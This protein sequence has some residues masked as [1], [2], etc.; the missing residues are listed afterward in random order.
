MPELGA[1]ARIDHFEIL[2]LLGQGGMG[3]V[4]LAVDH[5]LDR[6][7]AIKFLPDSLDDDLGRVRRFETEARAA[8]AL[9]HPNIVTIFDW[10]KSRWGPYLVMEWIEG[11]R[12]RELISEGIPLPRLLSL[13]R[14]AA[15]AISTAHRAGIV[16]R[17]LKPDNILVRDD[18]YV[19][20][21]DFGL[22]R[23]TNLD[24]DAT[25]TFGG[26]LMG[27]LKYLAPEQGAGTADERSDVF[28]LGLIFYQMATGRH[29]FEAGSALAT[30][31][32]LSTRPAIPPAEL[33]PGIPAELSAL[34]L[35]MLEK[36]PAARPNSSHVVESLREMLS[37]TVPG[38][39]SAPMPRQTPAK[40]IVGRD[41][42]NTVL[43]KAFESAESVRGSLV[44]VS[45]E[46]GM[47]KTALVESVIQTLAVDRRR[48][49][50]GRGRSSQ[51]LAGVEAYAP[52]LEALQEQLH[53]DASG[54]FA[55]EMKQFAPSWYSLVCSVS[56]LSGSVEVPRAHSQDRMKQELATMLQRVGRETPLAIV[57]EDFH[58][59][60][61]S[62]VDAVVHLANRFDDLR[63][64]MIVTY[65]KSEML[66]SN[67]PFVTAE[68]DLRARGLSQEVKLESLSRSE[69]ERYVSLEFPKNR[70]GPELLDKVYRRTGGHPL[71]VADLI[72]YLR[73][74][75]AITETDGMWETA[76]SFAELE[77]GLPE[78][79]RSM[80]ERK[81]GAVDEDDRRLL[82]SAAVQGDEFDSAVL[83]TVVRM[84]AAEVEER[85]EHLERVY[86]LISLVEER[87]MPDRT[88]TCRY[89]FAHS[90]YHEYCY[91]LLRPTRRAAIAGATA[92]RLEECYGSNA[93]EIAS[94]LAFL[95]EGA[96]EFERAGE[97]FLVAANN[98]TALFAHRESAAMARRGLEA[99]RSL[100][101][102]PKRDSQELR[103]QL[104]LGGSLCMTN[105]YASQDTI[106][107]FS[108]ALDLAKASG[109]GAPHPVI[110]GLWMAYAIM[111]DSRRSRELSD[112]LL[113]IASEAQ[114]PLLVATAHYASAITHE[115]AGDL[116]AAKSDVDQLIAIGAHDSN[117]RRVA[118]FVVDPL[119]SGRGIHLRTLALMGLG[120]MA[121]AR[122][123]S[124][125][126]RLD[127]EK[128]DPRSAC[129]I[130][131]SGC[132]YYAFLRRA[133]DV[134]ELAR[135]AAELSER[136]DIFVERQW[137]AFWH[138]WALTEM[139]APG[140]GPQAM[141]AFLNLITSA[142]FLL[143]HSL[144]IATFGEALAKAGE[145][146]EAGDWIARGLALV[147]RTG[148]HYYESELHRIRGEL[149]A[150]SND[151]D[152]A[153]SS[154]KRALEIATSQEARLL[155]IRAALS[156]ARF[157]EQEGSGAEAL[158]VLTDSVGRVT[159]GLKSPEFSEASQACRE[160][161][162]SI[163]RSGGLSISG[164]AHG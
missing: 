90:L 12:L 105:G 30:F 46:A 151:R 14:Q 89:R 83:S 73:E 159:A 52:L 71:F 55:R 51:R 33:N 47:G 24:G 149:A 150:R 20:V 135:R 34:V 145:L 130:L 60:D 74:S 35:N 19:K 41:A 134:R 27:T 26:M 110:W 160:L 1:G 121:S 88:L 86:A 6:K 5:R 31:H 49:L 16:H 40:A 23:L 102:S 142:G 21:V 115:I 68:L 158:R 17:D 58:W 80:V 153:R 139:G 132:C 43:L 117:P 4:Y 93:P 70:F 108:R 63:L 138:G 161:S 100:P 148:Q 113:R 96:R 92:R 13:A 119:I 78:S 32:A 125:R 82:S 154:L 2:S 18:G 162:Q 66:Q 42:E 50:L 109:E 144:Y 38:A 44:C 22:A 164:E 146:D 106:D 36:E 91:G 28:S 122:W 10:G 128:L 97:Y 126:R 131:I 3:Q 163:E 76:P 53:S 69:V 9:N 107:C 37:S 59:A 124:H 94:K 143:H 85:L 120:D 140:E 95:F 137:A 99:V 39:A 155:E 147:E 7:V 61:I 29:P 141:R 112:D 8:S 111:G 72:R 57:F 118:R 25:A 157:L 104:A 133:E 84:D 114:D 127:A 103:L 87:E 129:D 98:A 75:G 54:R 123:E 65:R 79:V 62:T 15:E 152:E 156:M 64:M 77:Q 116:L 136:F 45:G 101:P 81:M 11:R 48:C 67:H 56:E